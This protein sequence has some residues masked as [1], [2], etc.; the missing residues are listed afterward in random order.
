MVTDSGHSI[1]IPE[2]LSL[3]VLGPLMMKLVAL[4]PTRDRIRFL[5]LFI[6]ECDAFSVSSETVGFAFGR[7]AIIPPVQ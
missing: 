6:N 3:V 5:V 7:E 4:P 2:P 1:S